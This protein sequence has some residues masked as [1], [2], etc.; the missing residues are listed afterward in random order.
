[1]VL[2]AL[3]IVS[4]HVS[5]VDPPF[6]NQQFHLGAELSFQLTIVGI[7]GVE[8]LRCAGEETMLIDKTGHFAVWQDGAPAIAL[9]LSQRA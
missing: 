4:I 2:H 7:A 1:M 6:S 8:L 5:E 9:P 3:Q